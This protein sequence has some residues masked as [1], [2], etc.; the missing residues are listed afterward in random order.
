[1]KHLCLETRSPDRGIVEISVTGD[2]DLASSESLHEAVDRG[3][4]HDGVE[5]LVIDLRN[6]T[7]IDSTGLRAL[8]RAREQA[9]ESSIELVLQAPSS[10]VRRL[11]KLTKLERVFAVADSAAD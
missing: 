8:W 11:L 5:M 7:F 2:L 6:V 9:Q 1:M 10:V 4:Q 3:R